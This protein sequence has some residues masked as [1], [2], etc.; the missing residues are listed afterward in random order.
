MVLGSGWSLRLVF[1]S[2]LNWN[3][4]QTGRAADGQLVRHTDAHIYIWTHRQADEAICQRV[5]SNQT[6]SQPTPQPLSH[7]ATIPERTTSPEACV[8]N[9]QCCGTRD[10]GIQWWVY[11]GIPSFSV[12]AFVFVT[13]LSSNEENTCWKNSLAC[14]C[15]CVDVWDD[16]DEIQKYTSG[17][18]SLGS[19]RGE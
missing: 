13:A 5:P 1:S 16:E 15:V 9:R 4:S 8:L 19:E 6:S 12:E 3:L 18:T 11:P 17:G 2:A 7:D 10:L 14:V